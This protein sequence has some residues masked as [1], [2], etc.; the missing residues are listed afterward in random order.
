MVFM[1]PKDMQSVLP[2]IF[3]KRNS[4]LLI[5]PPSIVKVRVFVQLHYDKNLCS[6]EFIKFL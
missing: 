5:S 6:N 2:Q 3:C 1:V 4:G